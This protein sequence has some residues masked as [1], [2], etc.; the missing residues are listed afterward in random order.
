MSTFNSLRVLELKVP[1]P[2]VGLL[3]GGF[4]WLASKAV[5]SL[6][7][8][9]PH[10]KIIGSALCAAGVSIAGLGVASFR[11]AKTTMNPM[12]PEK[13]SALVNS[14]IYQ[15]TR[16]P[17]YLGM[18]L[19]LLGWA[20]FMSNALAFVFLPVFILYLNRFQIGPEE[21]ALSSAFGQEFATYKAKVRRWL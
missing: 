14:G 5:P 12:K 18:L 2:I 6:S 8:T 10:W 21:R 4:G 17:M 1:P 11:L 19:V 13:A 9:L 15:Y 20:V 3:M 7:F 16:N